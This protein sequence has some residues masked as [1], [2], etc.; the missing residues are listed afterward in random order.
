MYRLNVGAEQIEECIKTGMFAL[1][2]RPQI[3]VGEI[4]LLQLKKNDWKLLGAKGGRIQ[5]ALVFQ[6][7]EYDQEGNISK[8]HWPNGGK[9]W[10]GLFTHRQR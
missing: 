6:R 5:H 9:V 7:V 4:L 10:H 1:T 2:F 3:E 8:E